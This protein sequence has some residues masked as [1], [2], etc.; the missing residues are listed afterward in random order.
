MSVEGTTAI[1]TIHSEVFG[2]LVADAHAP[3]E[4]TDS[5]WQR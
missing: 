1:L 2:R 3:R 4:A 5:P